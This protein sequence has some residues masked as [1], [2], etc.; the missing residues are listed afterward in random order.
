ME[1]EKK[2]HGG[3]LFTSECVTVG[4][5]DKLADYISDSILTEILSKDKDARVA[6]ETMVS[7]N[8][9]VIAGEVTSVISN[10]E[11]DYDGIARR[12]IREVGYT[13]EGYGFNDKVEIRTNVHGQSPDIAMGVDRGGAGDQGLMFGGAWSETSDDMPLP[14]SMARAMALDLTEL[15]KEYSPEN[16]PN[17]KFIFPDGKTQVTISYGKGRVVDYIDTVVVSV[18][19][20]EDW[21]KEELK[22]LVK[23]RVVKHVVESF[24]FT[25]DD[26][27]KVF[28]NP[29]GKFVQ[30]GPAADVGLTGRKII[31]DTYGGYCP[32]GGG[33]FSGKDPSKVD[34]SG[35]YLARYISKNVVEAGIAEKCE[36][37]IAYAIGV[38]KPVSVNLNMFGTNKYPIGLISKAVYN[39]FDMTPNGIQKALGLRE[40]INYAKLSV[41]GHFGEQG[42]ELPW[43]QT[44][45]AQDLYQFCEDNYYTKGDIQIPKEFFKDEDRS[46]SGRSKKNG[47]KK[48]KNRRR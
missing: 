28:I 26:V 24:G 36:V 43:E 8:L 31:V 30:H 22:D 35:A 33:A 47:G 44:D 7:K 48:G 34:R 23:D 40:G 14:I 18:A 21:K 13:Y 1:Q 20:S 37:Q 16:S 29:T 45:K 3:S 5:P 12:A 6:V 25:M 9:V 42:D 41:T 27:N 10:S 46:N 4:H 11:I 32:H 19:H 15:S 38:A 2:K 17:G 39:V